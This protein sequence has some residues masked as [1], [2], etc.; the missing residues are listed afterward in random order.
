MFNEKE[1]SVGGRLRGQ[2]EAWKRHIPKNLKLH[3]KIN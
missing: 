1:G 3:Y 2:Q